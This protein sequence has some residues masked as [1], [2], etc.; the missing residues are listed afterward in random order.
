MENIDG[1]D[2]FQDAYETPPMSSSM[3]LESALNEARIAV[4]YFFNNKF[5]EARRTLEPW[6]NSSMY[7]AVGH[8]VFTFLEAMLTF[9]HQHIEKASEALKQCMAVCNRYRRKNTITESIGKM[10]K[11]PNYDLYTAEEVHAELCYAEAL[12]LKSLLT[13]VEDETLVSFIKAGI[14]IRSCYNSYKECANIL[15]TRKWN[16]ESYKVHFES[17]V[18]MGIGAFNLMISLLPARVIKLLEFIGFSGNKEVGL[19]EL[20]AGYQLHNSIRQVL[21]VMTLLGYHLIV[22]Y[23]LSHTDGDLD[24][25]DEILSTQLKMYPEGAWFLFFKGRLE[26]MK[27]NIDDAIKWYISSWKSQNMW[28]QFHHMCFWELMWTNSVKQNWHEASEFAGRLFEESRWSKT[29]YAYQKAAMLCMLGDDLTDDEQTEIEYLMRHA[30]QWKQRIAGKSLP[31]EKFAV[32]K[33]ERYFSQGK[34]LVLP[35]YELMYVWNLF[36][37]I[38][39]KWEMLDSV[40][41]R[42][43]KVL[44]KLESTREEGEY[45]ADNKA[46]VLLLKGTCLRLMNTPLQAEESLNIV[47]SLEKKIKEDL[48]LIPYAMVELALL[49]RSQ[50]DLSRA[51]QLLEDAK[52]NY[53]GYSLESRLHFKIHSFQSELNTRKSSDETTSELSSQ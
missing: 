51:A 36:K 19:R 34:S 10:V 7:H 17:G 48:Y 45:H 43:D 41:K 28:V 9:E 44:R 11:K 30:P 18:R 50:N 40:Y 47:L 37:Q 23:V 35:G 49:Y 13:F 33:S 6:A 32:K 42:V 5:D 3:D 39:K 31:M 21:C 16:N 1:D 15:H 12:L 4:N 25:C 46:L 14:K 20:Q 22:L 53:T 38:G 2:E 26:F 8:S 52:K 29:I 24:F 27:A